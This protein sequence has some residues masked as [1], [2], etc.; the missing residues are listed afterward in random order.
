MNVLH[1][2]EQRNSLEENTLQKNR[3]SPQRVKRTVNAL[4]IVNWCPRIT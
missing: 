2:T 4:L 3:N 1:H